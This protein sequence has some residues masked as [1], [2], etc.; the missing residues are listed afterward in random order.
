[1]DQA[2][3]EQNEQTPENLHNVNN[4][5]GKP[6]QIRKIQKELQDPEDYYYLKQYE[7]KAGTIVEYGTS[8]SGIGIYRVQFDRA[9]DGYFYREDFDIV[10]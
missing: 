10:D 4:Q 1:M 6:V 2:V 7:N 5:L 3:E 9:N 8:E